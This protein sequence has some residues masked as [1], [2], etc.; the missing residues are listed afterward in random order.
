MTM[1]F[2][3]RRMAICTVDLGNSE[4][5]SVWTDGRGRHISAQ[6]YRGGRGLSLTSVRSS[7][8]QGFEEQA[9]STSAV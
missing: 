3:L 2:E 5:T 6:S 8:A 7:P 4:P 1:A 9:P